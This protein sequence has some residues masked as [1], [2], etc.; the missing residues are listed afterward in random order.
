MTEEREELIRRQTTDLEATLD[1]HNHMAELRRERDCLQQRLDDLQTESQAIA[2]SS[3][4]TESEVGKTAREWKVLA[5]R[6]NGDATR[7]REERGRLKKKVTQLKADL[8]RA[9]FTVDVCREQ[10][11]NL[12]QAVPSAGSMSQ[13]PATPSGSRM[14]THQEMG[15][16][17]RLSAA[18]G[19]SPLLAVTPEKQ[20][21]PPMLTPM[22]NITLGP[23]GIDTPMPPR[24]TLRPS[25]SL[26]APP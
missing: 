5:D 19:P 6:L 9:N 14:P 21:V 8:A 26:A 20:S 1:Q 3:T 23:R 13:A 25:A 22:G 4:S 12:K 17:V 15:G 2:T 18:S 7:I 10:L 11:E 16:H 24:L